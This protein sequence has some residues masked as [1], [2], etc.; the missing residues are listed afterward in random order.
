MRTNFRNSTYKSTFRRTSRKASEKIVRSKR[1]VYHCLLLAELQIE[2]GGELG[3]EWPLRNHAWQFSS[4]REF[5]RRHHELFHEAILHGCRVGVKAQNGLLVKKPWRIMTTDKRLQFALHR[6]CQCQEPHASFNDVNYEKT[7]FYPPQMCS[8]IARAW[9]K[10]QPV[11]EAEIQLAVQKTTSD[12]EVLAVMP[13][14][15]V[16]AILSELPPKEKARLEKDIKLIHDNTGHPPNSVLLRVLRDKK[17]ETKVLAVAQ[18]F[19]CPSCAELHRPFPHQVVTIETCTTLWH[20]VAMDFAVLKH[21]GTVSH[22]LLMID[23]ASHKLVGSV[24]LEHADTVSKNVTTQTVIEILEKDWIQHYGSPRILRYDPEGCFRSRA[25]EEW[26]SQLRIEALPIPGEDHAQLG[27]IEG[28]VRIVKEGAAKLLKDNP[29]LSV[30]QATSRMICAHNTL[31][32]VRGFSPLQWAQGRDIEMDSEIQD[33]TESI[34]MEKNLRLRLE[35]EAVFRHHQA[36]EKINRAQRYQ[37]RR[38]YVWKPGDCVLYRRKGR[39]GPNQPSKHTWMGPGRVFG[40]ETRQVDGMRRP[41]S[42]VW[43]VA[44]G[45][46]KRCGPSQLRLATARE[47]AYARLQGDHTFS[48]PWTMQTASAILERGE[49]DD[50][51]PEE[52][53]A[54]DDEGPATEEVSTGEIPASSTSMPSRTLPRSRSP[55]QRNGPASSSTTPS[56]ELQEHIR[57]R[58]STKRPPEGDGSSAQIDD[59]QEGAHDK[60][61]RV[62]ELQGFV[63]MLDENQLD[64]QS[65]HLQE[66]RRCLEELEAFVSSN[67]VEPTT[68]ETHWSHFCSTTGTTDEDNVSVQFAFDLNVH[69][70]KS[71]RNFE[72]DSQCW[73]LTQFTKQKRSAKGTE[74]S[75]RNLSTDEVEKFRKAKDLEVQQWVQE[76][77]VSK[78]EEF[79]PAERL[80]RMRWVLTWKPLEDGSG[81]SKAKARIVVLGY[82]DPEADTL[83]TSSPTLTRRT[84]QLVLQMMAHRRWT[85]F[86]ADAKTAF[87]QGKP[88]QSQRRVYSLPVPELAAALGI[89]QHEAVRIDKACY[90]L[91]NAPREWYLDV[92]KTLQSLGFER[93]FT[94][95]CCWIL[96]DYSQEGSPVI[97]IICSHV[98]DFLLGGDETSKLWND[99]VE[100]IRQAYKWGP[101][102][103]SDFTHC[104][105]RIRQLRDY[106]FLIDQEEYCNQIDVIELSKERAKAETDCITSTERSQLRGV[107][108]ALQWKVSQTGPQHAVQLSLLQSQVEKG[109]VKTL[110]EANKLVR[111]VRTDKDQVLMI[112]SFTRDEDL[113]AVTWTDGALANRPD[114]G[115][116]GGFLVGMTTRRLVD[117]EEDSVSTIAW[118]SARLPRIARS[119]LSCEVQS[120]AEGDQELW[121]V[122]L[123]WAEMNGA[124]IDRRNFAATVQR[125]P[126]MIV[127]DARACYDAIHK[128]LACAGSALGLKEKNSAAEL[129]ALMENIESSATL[130]RWVHS[131]AQLA[132]G[133][134]KPGAKHV[135]KEFLRTQ[136]WRI[137]YDDRMRSAKVRAKEGLSKFDTDYRTAEHREMPTYFATGFS[138]AWFSRH[139]GR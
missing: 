75:L 7:G 79:V 109:T 116:T 19:Q 70:R 23:E 61:P 74:V 105:C 96:K 66:A 103:D 93:L 100:G 34:D 47:Q 12:G 135:I 119:S 110:L 39:A 20:T 83:P 115:S 6:Q 106:S 134:T 59:N 72:R 67:F 54:T 82:Q 38:D 43:I 122:R 33:P 26:A 111:E 17:V 5:Y 25:L 56:T 89:S 71:F 35:A 137:T 24:A 97:G 114:F 68:P 123:Q 18:R 44:A 77:A 87:L 108:G 13:D 124:V 130:V 15:E 112:H 46:L 101:W 16:D 4:V 65:M 50:Y 40:T 95:P 92:D 133:L 136:R 3:W 37:R 85:C 63:S 80:M 2:Q 129:M 11:T 52:G 31:D 62:A 64:E 36:R 131:N 117:G 73:I 132:D 28:S 30:Q 121:F 76:A 138:L 55:R 84:R 57:R 53:E 86:K 99:T 104:G 10:P 51:L 42:V 91:I 139:F 107:L 21:A 128:G 27:L 94:E 29:S 22:I 60:R 125:T 126:G 78:A 41:G 90:G 48:M 69:D 9:T 113:I 118:R 127:I 49:F 102:E 98:D 14:D 45:R 32:R 81:E 120:C 8:I 58:I 88:T 1:I